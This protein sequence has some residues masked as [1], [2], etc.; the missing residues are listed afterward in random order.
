MMDVETWSIFSFPTFDRAKIQRNASL[1][2]GKKEQCK[3]I[4]VKEIVGS[5]RAVDIVV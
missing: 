4:N 5:G 2:E 1:V 3:V